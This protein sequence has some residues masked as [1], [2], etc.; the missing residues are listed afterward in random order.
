M[1]GVPIDGPTNTSYDNRSVCANTTRSES[2]L[3][4]NY[5]IIDYC[6][7]Q[8]SVAVGKV[9]IYYKENI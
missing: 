2:T 7:T 1:F 3:T 6:H 4:N 5:H 8:E 9:I